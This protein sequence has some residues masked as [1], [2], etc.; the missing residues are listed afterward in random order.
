M[1]KTKTVKI[2]T[3]QDSVSFD[4][5]KNND[6]LNLT[7]TYNNIG[8]NLFN[9]TT[10]NNTGNNNSNNTNKMK[11]DSTF[12][13]QTAIIPTKNKLRQKYKK[14]KYKKKITKISK[15][16]NLSKKLI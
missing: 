3:E 1:N 16:L 13:N 9:I 11:N 15:K 2:K 14:N 8:K 5:G 12:K 7:V 4:R 6:I 10:D